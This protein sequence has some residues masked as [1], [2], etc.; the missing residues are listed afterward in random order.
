[1]CHNDR[2]SHKEKTKT[3]KLDLVSLF[4]SLSKDSIKGAPNQGTVS[5]LEENYFFAKK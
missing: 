5:Q 2:Q 3:L 1:M 4:F